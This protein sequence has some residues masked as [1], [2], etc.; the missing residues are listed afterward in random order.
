MEPADEKH[1]YGHGKFENV[2]GVIEAMLIVIAAII[3]IY[4]A[5]NRLIKGGVVEYLVTVS[6]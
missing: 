2:S 6:Q 1:P 4:E 5:T 3:I